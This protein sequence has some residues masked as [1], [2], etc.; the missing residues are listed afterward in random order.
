MCVGGGGGGGG[1]RNK[2]LEDAIA[3]KEDFFLCLFAFA[4]SER[5]RPNLGKTRH[6]ARTCKSPH[7]HFQYLRL[8]IVKVQFLSY[9]CLLLLSCLHLKSVFLTIIECCERVPNIK[10]GDFRTF[11]HTETL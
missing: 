4:Q 2:D 10:I 6:V 5:M 11:L 1:K 7:A 9:S 8:K 3:C